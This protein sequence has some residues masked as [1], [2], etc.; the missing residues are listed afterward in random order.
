MGLG[1][2]KMICPTN[3]AQDAQS[4]F[5]TSGDVPSIHRK[6]L[7]KTT[8]LANPQSVCSLWIVGVQGVVVWYPKYARSKTVRV[9]SETPW[10]YISDS[11]LFC[12]YWVFI[13]Q[14]L[15]SGT[16][17]AIHKYPLNKAKGF[18]SSRGSWATL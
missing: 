14:S 15:D 10:S 9:L 12:L 7:P 4:A 5:N 17:R 13:G 1:S 2:H 16:T 8:A 18:P 3:E 11:S 6:G